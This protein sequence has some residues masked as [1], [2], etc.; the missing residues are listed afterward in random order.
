MEQV[1]KI[2]QTI[3]D[4][5]LINPDWIVEVATHMDGY[6]CIN[7]ED[8]EFFLDPK[9]YEVKD[10]FDYTDANSNFVGIPLPKK[11]RA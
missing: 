9:D 6:P 3:A 7:M 11:K 5:L 8:A 10:W 2:S 4:D 1:A